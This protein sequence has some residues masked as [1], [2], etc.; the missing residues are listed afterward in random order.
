MIKEDHA[1]NG[2]PRGDKCI[3]HWNRTRSSRVDV[4]PACEG[5]V[6]AA[7]HVLV[8]AADHAGG[9]QDSVTE[10]GVVMEDRVR[11]V[12]TEGGREGGNQAEKSFGTGGDGGGGG[13]GGGDDA[14]LDWA[15]IMGSWR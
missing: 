1:F 4:P 5:R 8:A 10:T 3:R 12:S 6:V 13:G 11:E 15:K 2:P 14:Q 7:D 9:R